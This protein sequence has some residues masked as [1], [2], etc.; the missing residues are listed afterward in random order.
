M[1]EILLIAGSLSMDA[2]AVSVSSAAC[3]KGLTRFHM[4][5]AA[6]AFGLFQ[7]LMPLVGAGVGLAFS[8]FIASFDHW[9]AFALLA[10]VGGKM[11]VEVI[12]EWKESP[13]ACECPVDGEKKDIKS[14]R[15]L[16][17]LS[18]ATSIDALAIGMSF[19]VIGRPILSSSLIIGAVTFI[20]CAGGFFFGRKVGC[21]LGRYAQLAGG[22]VLIGI[23]ARI[24]FNH[25]TQG[26]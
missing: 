5:R 17:A 14:K 8:S 26:L 1:I 19:A 4:L 16:L 13:N 12:K 11:L 20:I 18:V 2:F 21:L 10:L 3:S 22:L 6:F 15:I 24:L 25:L 7:F 9:V 23:G